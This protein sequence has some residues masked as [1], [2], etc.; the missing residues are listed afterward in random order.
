[1]YSY[2]IRLEVSVQRVIGHIEYA[3]EGEVKLPVT[4]EPD[5]LS[6]DKERI[7]QDMIER[8]CSIQNET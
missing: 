8:M 7:R 5:I 4:E 6:W 2:T 3:V 1:M